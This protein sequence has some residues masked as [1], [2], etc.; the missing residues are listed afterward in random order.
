M[1]VVLICIAV[2]MTLLAKNYL[3][4]YNQLFFE[5]NSSDFNEVLQRINEE[6]TKKWEL[7]EEIRLEL[8]DRGYVFGPNTGM[9]FHL[10]AE[11]KRL[12]ICCDYYAE[13]TKMLV[14]INRR[15]VGSEGYGISWNELLKSLNEMEESGK[16]EPQRYILFLKVDKSEPGDVSVNIYKYEPEGIN[17]NYL[18]A[19]KYSIPVISTEML[20]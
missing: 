2:C 18:D 6:I 11:G 4:E 3:K 14:Y 8:S 5:V 19:I 13:S 20:E 16:I 12:D 15:S 10:Y 9:D 7:E 17:I 1:M